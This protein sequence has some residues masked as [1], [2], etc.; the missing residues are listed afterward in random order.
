MQIYADVL[1]LPITSTASRP[2]PG[3]RLGDP[4]RRRRRRLHADVRRRRARWAGC[5]RDASTC[6]IR[7]RAD[8]YDELYAEYRGCTTTSAGAPNGRATTCCTACASAGTERRPDDRSEPTRSRRLR[9]QVGRAARR[10]RPL[11]ARRLDRRATS[12]AG[13][14]AHDLFVIKPSGVGYD[15]LTPESMVVVRPRRQR[16]RGRPRPRRATPPPTPTS[17]GTCPRSAAS[18]TPTPPTPRAWAARG[19][20]IPCV[21]TAMA[22]E[23]GGRHPG[24]AV[25]AHRRRLHRPR[26]RRD[27]RRPPLARGADAQPRR[28][29]DRPRRPRRGQGGGDVR[30]RRPHRAPRA[31][32]R[33]AAAHRPRRRSTRLYDRYQNVYGQPKPDPDR[34]RAVT[35]EWSASEHARPPRGLVPHRQPGPVRRGDPAPGR[36]PVRRQIAARARRRA[37][38]PGPRS[39]GSRCSP[40]PDGDP[41][42]RASTPTPTT[43]CIG[44]I[45]WMHTFSPGQDVDRRARARSA[46]RCCTC[47]PRPTSRCRGRTSTW[48]S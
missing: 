26:H 13:S 44:V 19:E 1:R 25:R 10:A 6:P 37:G 30:G 38:R 35:T 16:R 24:R 34:Q 8:A 2:G 48:T 32:A 28:V 39:S 22:D 31:P 4:R 47:T 7:R 41:P 29:H 12:P 14:P 27:A 15:E 33:R 43:P 42:A 11:R 46:S 9:E 40:T 5:E 3:A 20:P 36:R 17:T 18:C 23:F 21:L 45:A